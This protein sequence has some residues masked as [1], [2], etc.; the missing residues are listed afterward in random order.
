MSRYTRRVSGV[1]L[2][3]WRE[4]LRKP[5]DCFVRLLQE[6]TTR[7]RGGDL[8]SPLNPLDVH[9][10]IR[11]RLLVET[12]GLGNDRVLDPQNSLV[13]TFY[14]GPYIRKTI[15]WFV[16]QGKKHEIQTWKQM[17]VML[18]AFVAEDNPK[19]FDRVE[20]IA[21]EGRYR[22]LFAR[23]KSKLRSPRRIGS[24]GFFV[25]TNLS[26]NNIYG[27]CATLLDYFGYDVDDRSVFW[28]NVDEAL[29]SVAT[30]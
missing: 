16:F 4:I 18:C 13:D 21:G 20:A 11:N 25:E 24:T 2:K 28:T 14:E 5:P 27:L 26:A 29:Q 12:E 1:L 19:T 30:T 17:L 9:L 7:R 8:D 23:D 10:F 22:V 15:R 3:T 6:E